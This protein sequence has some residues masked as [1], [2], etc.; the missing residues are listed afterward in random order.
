MPITEET[1]ERV[2]LEDPD[3]KWEL[4]CG[5]LR[6][7]PAMTAKHNQIGRI[8]GFRLQ[9]QL[10]LDAYEVSIDNTWVRI[11]ATR[12]YIP[13]VAVLPTALVERMKQEQPTH[14]EVHRDPLPL[15]VEVWSPSTGKEDL[16]EKLPGYQGRGDAEIWLIRHQ[17]RALI[18]SVREPDGSY[19]EHVYH[20]GVIHPRALPNVAIDLDELFRL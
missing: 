14:L 4:H 7:K 5:R 18:A 11:S 8:L 2:A 6:S 16:T 15:I 20:G 19:S 12:T 10:A 9:Q 17:E 1:F 3:G 13:D